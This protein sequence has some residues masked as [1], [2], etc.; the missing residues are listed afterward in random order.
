MLQGKERSRAVAAAGSLTRVK[1]GYKFLAENRA[2]SMALL[3]LEQTAAEV[4]SHQLYVT[5][6]HAGSRPVAPETGL[7]SNCVCAWTQHP[8]LLWNAA[9]K[10]R[11]IPCQHG[12]HLAFKSPCHT[13]A[14]VQGFTMQAPRRRPHS[15]CAILSSRSGLAKSQCLLGMA[16][17]ALHH[18]H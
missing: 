6:W 4:Q 18:E 7:P 14:C 1:P 3:R 2:G 17:L 16:H 9:S 5:E 12:C 13:S 15:A 11:I 8:L 10:G